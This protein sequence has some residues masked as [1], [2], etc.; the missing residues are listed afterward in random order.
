MA[1]S[2]SSASLAL[3]ADNPFA[4]PSALP[5]GLPDFAAIRPEHYMPAFNAGIA[6]QE[7]LLERIAADP[8]KPTFENTVELLD[9]GSALLARVSR[10]FF[11]EMGGNGTEEL[12]RIE[13]EISPR[14][15]A[16]ADATWLS[17]ELF[18]RVDAVHAAGPRSDREEQQILEQMHQRFVLRGA[19]LDEAGRAQLAELN[20]ELSTLETAF[21]QQVRA[22]LK[23]AAVHVRDEVDLAGLDAAQLATA[24]TAAQDAGLDGF[25][26]TLE[27]PT[28]QGLLGSLTVRATREKLHRASLQR[29]EET[30]D[31]ARRIADARARKA[32]L[33]GFEDFASLAVADRTAKTPSAV[34]ELFASAVPAAMRNVDREAARIAERAAADGITDLEPWDWA[35][36]ENRVRAEDFAV[37]EAALQP[38]L[39]LDRVLV[40]GV[41][42]AAHEVYGLTFTERDDLTAHHELARIWEVFDADG[43]GI[44]LFIG[45]FF[46]RDTKRGGAWMNAVVPQ[47][48][49]HGMRPVI[50][51]T[52]NISRPAP[53][54]P[55]YVSLDQVRTLFHEFGHALHGLLS[56]VDRASVSGTSVARD[57]VEFPS[58]VNEMWA[59]RDGIVEHWARHVDTDEPIPSELL[60]A[61]RTSALWGEGFSTVEYLAAAVLDWRWHRL[62]PEQIPSDPHAF[63]AQQLEQEHLAHPL[64]APRYR[65]GYFN[66]TF[67]G[68]YAAGYYSYFWAEVFDADAVAWF[69]EQLTAGNPLREIGDRFC[70]E[71][72][73]LGGS[74][75]M[76]DAYRALRGKDRDV[77]HLL[78]RRG[79]L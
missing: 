30:W 60:Q 47:S 25:L 17:P 26:L 38:Y 19:R 64:V 56:D 74:V 79:L 62:A 51:N 27:L 61:V 75:D 8:A 41:F 2:H 28:V 37:D 24:R 53:G 57:V 77:R 42:R 55:A 7:A 59:L 9:E 48:R 15:A 31:L 32:Q 71:L 52:L 50:A 29:G 12:I 69:E 35:Y 67:S 40:D 63:E 66:H 23:A 65:T 16:L 20:Q 22:D 68:S 58:Q 5:Y 39:V 49:R 76:V 70:R 6:Q 1:P 78:E 73:A 54:Q 45:D 11:H 21:A 14:L 33:L 34:D 18:A 43:T 36:Y 10:V 4:S 13:S 46:T 3:P 72:L 44:G